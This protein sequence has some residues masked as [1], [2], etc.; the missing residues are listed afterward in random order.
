M[1]DFE[2]FATACLV[3]VG[4]EHIMLSVDDKSIE[5]LH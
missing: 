4:V 2:A 5:S 3:S 1:D